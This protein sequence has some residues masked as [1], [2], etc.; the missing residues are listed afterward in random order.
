MEEEHEKGLK[1]NKDTEIAEEFR[2][3]S[4]ETFGETKRRLLV[5]TGDDFTS[6]K[7]KKR[8]SGSETFS[9][10]REKNDQE[11][12]LRKE[13]LEIRKREME[14]IQGPNAEVTYTSTKSNYSPTSATAANI[15]CIFK[16]YEQVYTIII[17]LLFFLKEKFF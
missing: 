10:L 11:L 12:A 8:R 7:Q 6:P 5:E 2:N 9:Y 14:E 15:N 3:V 4:L 17:V 1:T 13:E 16:L